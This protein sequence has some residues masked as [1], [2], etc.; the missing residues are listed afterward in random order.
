MLLRSTKRAYFSL[1]ELLKGLNSHRDR[2]VRISEA[3]GTVPSLRNSQFNSSVLR[4]GVFQFLHE[5][6][7]I[8]VH[9]SNAKLDVG[10][11]RNSLIG[12]LSSFE[13][14]GSFNFLWSCFGVNHLNDL[15]WVFFV[16]TERWRLSFEGCHKTL[17]LIWITNIILPFQI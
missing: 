8:W 11:F 12:R 7:G 14:G 9:L 3:I 10:N 2:T 13:L 5:G 6:K 17:V 15:V 16:G 4:V 1:F